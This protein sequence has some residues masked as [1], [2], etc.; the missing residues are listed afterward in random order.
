M[1]CVALDPQDFRGQPIYRIEFDIDTPNNGKEEGMIHRYAMC[2][3]VVGERHSCFISLYIHF[4]LSITYIRNKGRLFRFYFPF[5]VGV[6][7]Y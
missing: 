4:F 5:S 3:L 7:L 1:R 6:K 2:P